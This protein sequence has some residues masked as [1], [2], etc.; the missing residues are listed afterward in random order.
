MTSHLNSKSYDLFRYIVDSLHINENTVV[1]IIASII[2]M[3]GGFTAVG[4]FKLIVFIQ[5]IAIGGSTDILELLNELPWYVKLL[6]PSIGGVIAG[7]LIYYFGQETKGHGVPEVMEAIALRSGRIRS[8]VLFLKTFVS[9]VTIGTG[10]SVGREGPIVQIGSSLGSTF[11]QWLRVGQ[12]RLKVLVAC[13]AAAGIAATFNAPLG[14]I[15][16]APY[17]A[18]ANCLVIWGQNPA[19]SASRIMK[20]MIRRRE[21]GEYKVIVI[22]PRRTKVAETADM[23]LQL[24]PGTDTAQPSG[25]RRTSE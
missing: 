9:A 13:G 19:E 14:G 2:G 23:W 20:S 11:G 8:R 3:C 16:F 5:T 24:R 21:K 7:P 10:G 22:D 15:F 25:A 12:E 18:R 17:I 6:L 1:L 4:F